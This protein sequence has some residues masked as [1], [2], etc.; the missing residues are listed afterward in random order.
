VFSLKANYPN[1]FDP[2]TTIKY[3]FAKT[4]MVRM[5]VFNMLGQEVALVTEGIQSVGAHEVTFDASKLTS[6]VYFY[7]LN[8]DG[9]QLIRKMVLLK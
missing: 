6:G 5:T 9:N 7:L 3:S 1:P 8:A 2:T 4:G